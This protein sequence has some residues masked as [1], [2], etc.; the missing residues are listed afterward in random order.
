MQ[1]GTNQAVIIPNRNYEASMQAFMAMRQKN[2]KNAIALLDR[3]R[4]RV[5]SVH[6]KEVDRLNRCIGNVPDYSGVVT[7]V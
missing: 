4:E 5:L 6:Q 7:N 1:R 3:A 2:Q